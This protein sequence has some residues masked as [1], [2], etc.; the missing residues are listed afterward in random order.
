MFHKR[1]P[2]LFLVF[3]GFIL[4]SG[5]AS[6]KPAVIYG[7]AHHSEKQIA[8]V[9]ELAGEFIASDYLILGEQHD[10]PEHHALQLEI[11]QD[12]HQKGWLKQIAMEMLVPSQQQAADRA[13]KNKITDLSELN[14]LLQ[15]DKGW[16]WDMYGPI[17]GWAVS[18]GIPLKAANLDKGELETTRATPAKLGNKVLGEAGVKVHKDQFRESH[19]GHIPAERAE[20]MLRVQVGRDIRMAASLTEQKGTVLLAGNWHARKDIGV[21]LYV[22]ANNPDAAVMTLGFIEKADEDISKS[23]LR[24]MYDVVWTT[25][26]V[27]RPDYCAMFKNGAMS[28]PNSRPEAEAGS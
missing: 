15:W 5:C 10:N 21:P 2:V 28:K 20:T 26:G 7:T 9:P 16:D 12:L 3:S 24:T 22:Q 17:V 14:T 11:L 8:S 27:E 1:L 25:G 19:C 18:Q 4:A 6:H 13:V 23:E